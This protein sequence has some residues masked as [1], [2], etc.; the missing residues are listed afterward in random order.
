MYEQLYQDYKGFICSIANRYR[1]Y[2]RTDRAVD[3]EDLVQVGFIGLVN[4][5]NTYDEN[6]PRT[7][8]MHVKACILR[9]IY[10]VLG[11]R[12]GELKKPH[13][14]AASMDAPLISHK[15]NSATLGEMLP[16]DTMPE[17]DEALMREE[18]CAC[19]RQAIDQLAD[20]RLR[21]LVELRDL[22]GCS[23]SEAASAMSITPARA[24]QLHGRALASLA[25]D[26]RLR[27]FANLDERTRFHAHKGVRAFMSD[28]TSVTEAAAL[29]RIEQ[30]ER[31][32]EVSSG[33]KPARLR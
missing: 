9:E 1:D 2:C 24:L 31:Q 19:V 33:E 29:W 5:Y 21:Q 22:S 3:V 23:L 27:A 25:R 20:P 11:I 16:D 14:L 30:R 17:L 15:A 10:S 18:T 28:R 12:N 4:A 26:R 7:W 32:Q 13:S 6:T 8:M